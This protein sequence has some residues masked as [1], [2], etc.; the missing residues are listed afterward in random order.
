MPPGDFL[1]FLN[2]RQKK[3]TNADNENTA[4]LDITSRDDPANSQSDSEAE[5]RSK[6]YG[7]FYLNKKQFEQVMESGDARCSVDIVAIHGI[8][9]HAYH[10]WTHQNGKMWLREFLPGQLPGAR[11]F[12]FGYPSEVAF[13]LSTG[14]L[15]DFARSLLEG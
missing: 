13:T 1:R 7:L 11:I 5:D 3:K 2:K 8:N 4:V 12:T 10:T 9:G 15:E 6:I 14:K